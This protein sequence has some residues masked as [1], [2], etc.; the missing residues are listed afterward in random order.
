MLELRKQNS[1]LT[2]RLQV[3]RSNLNAIRPTLAVA[4][5]E[6]RAVAERLKR[7]HS[8]KINEQLRLALFT[9]RRF[10]GSL[11]STFMT[12]SVA[13]AVWLRVVNGT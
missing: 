11:K 8:E 2:H 9:Q 13:N 7:Q 4:A 10:L 6:E 12:S 5:A 1:E 3:L